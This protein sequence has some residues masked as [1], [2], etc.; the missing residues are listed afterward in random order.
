V[1][2]EVYPYTIHVW[3]ASDLFKAGHRIQVEISS[4][5]FPMYDRNPD[6]GHVFGQDAELQSAQQVIYHHAD[7]P[8]SITLPIVD[9]PLQ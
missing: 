5:N 4:S 6:T 8:S 2:G 3:P 1:P 9:T 7:H